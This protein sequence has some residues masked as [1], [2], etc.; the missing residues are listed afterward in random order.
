MPS[1][2]EGDLPFGISFVMCS[3]ALSIHTDNIIS[4][5]SGAG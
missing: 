4:T 2:G 1:N 3:L 5:A